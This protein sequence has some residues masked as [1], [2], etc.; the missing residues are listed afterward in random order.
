MILSGTAAK[1]DARHSRQETLAAFFCAALRIAR[2]VRW[3]LLA[4]TCLCA[5]V[6][7]SPYDFA[8]ELISAEIGAFRREL[9][10][11]LDV[12]WDWF[13]PFPMCRQYT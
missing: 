6:D 7:R 4:V 11:F 9:L 13:R 3:G 5:C 10:E 8:G 1:E 12:I 2:K